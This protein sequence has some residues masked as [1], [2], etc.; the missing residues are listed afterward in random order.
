VHTFTISAY[1][2]HAIGE[3]SKEI[4]NESNSQVSL[5]DLSG[6]ESSAERSRARQQKRAP[7]D[8]LFKASNSK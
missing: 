1:K 6:R 2:L 7:V 5:G 4:L 3:E 8:A